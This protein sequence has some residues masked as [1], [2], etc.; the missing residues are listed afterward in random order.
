MARVGA[1]VRLFPRNCRRQKERVRA[2]HDRRVLRRQRR[3]VRRL[4]VR[5]L[6]RRSLPRRDG[7]S[8]LYV[9]RA[10]A[11]RQV[12]SKLQAFRRRRQHRRAEAVAAARR[13]VDA[14]K[15]DA[16]SRGHAFRRERRHDVRYLQVQSHRV[17]RRKRTD[18]Q[19]ALGLLLDAS[20]GDD[21][22]KTRV[23]LAVLVGHEP[24]K[25][26]LSDAF[27]SLTRADCVL[28]PLLAL[29]KRRRLRLRSPRQ[30]RRVLLASRKR[31]H[32]DRHSRRIVVHDGARG[33][34]SRTR[35]RWRQRHERRQASPAS[36]T[37]CC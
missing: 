2:L 15:A 23:E 5:R 7:R 30:P 12:D 27:H 10:V 13:E 3:E 21:E 18:D 1:G 37:S 33:D 31:R 26:P 19:R 9:L 11:E 25:E 6:G 29:V 35:E 20:G 22:R 8:P 24:S 17:T 4:G 28:Q 36:S 16:R 32:F 34:R 14:Q